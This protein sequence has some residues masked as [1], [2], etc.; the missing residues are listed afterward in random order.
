M[1]ISVF[2]ELERLRM[3][4]VTA[5]N[6]KYI[7]YTTVMLLSAGSN[8]HDHIKAYL[9]N[10]ELEKNDLEMMQEILSPYDVEVIGLHVDRK[11]FSENLLEN[12]QYEI[13]TYYKLVMM[14]LLPEEVDRFFYLAGNIIVNKSLDEFYSQQF[15]GMELIAC[16]D[17]NG[18]NT[19]ENCND[20]EQK[21][22]E[23]AGERENKCFDTDVLLVNFDII[24]SKYNFRFFADMMKRWNNKNKVNSKDIINRAH[25]GKVK[26][27]DFKKY[28]LFARI[29]HDFGINYQE[30]KEAVSIINFCGGKP[31]ENKDIHFDIEKIWWD[32]AKKTPFYN[33]LLTN[34]V[35]SAF[36][37]NS[38]E[39]NIEQLI[40]INQ[41]MIEKL[42]TITTGI[43]KAV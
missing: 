23:E 17:E 16:Y 24:K 9:L 33:S 4:I 7:P 41:S 36:D 1:G 37:D 26:Y 39:S 25:R 21:I 20:K 3:N 35:K 5:L 2:E 40:N 11:M 22:F 27:A 43:V 29:A 19:L 10:S 38:I 6:K 8:T 31:W 28:N 42:K 18:L 12:E 14:D 30:V 32:Y 15:E 13:E 34:F